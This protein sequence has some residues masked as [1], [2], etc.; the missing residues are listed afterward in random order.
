MFTQ[1][2][3]IYLTIDIE[4]TKTK[5]IMQV[6]HCLQKRTLSHY[7]K[8]LESLAESCCIDQNQNRLLL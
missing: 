1:S 2:R 4:K 8:H 5:N 6:I 3:G 7:L